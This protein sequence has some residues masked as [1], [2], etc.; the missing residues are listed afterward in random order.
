M[1]V[2]ITFP[3]QLFYL[4]INMNNG[5]LAYIKRLGE[6]NLLNFNVTTFSFYSINVIIGIIQRKLEPKHHNCIAFANKFMYEVETFN[7]IK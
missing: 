4:K 3:F 2:K 5:T 1:S 6:S 7:T